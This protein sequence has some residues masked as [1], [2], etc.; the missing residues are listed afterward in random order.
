[1]LEEHL[2]GKQYRI[3]LYKNTILDILEL[4]PPYIIGDGVNNIKTLILMENNKKKNKK[5]PL[6]MEE[7]FLQVKNLN[8]NSI[9]NKNEKIFINLPKGRLGCF[10]K[11]IN[12]K[13]VHKDNIIMFKK[14][15]KVAGFDFIGVDFI[16]NKLNLSYKNNINKNCGINELNSSPS[17]APHYIYKNILPNYTVPIKF[18]VLYFKIKNIKI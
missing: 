16:I 2:Y 9:L 11:R 14:L 18:F 7:H 10:G 12:I 6:I 13:N 3:L 17:I 1:M 5:Y 15:Y 4:I 8:V